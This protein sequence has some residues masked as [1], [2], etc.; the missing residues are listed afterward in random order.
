MDWNSNIG[1]IVPILNSCCGCFWRSTP[2]KIPDPECGRGSRL[3]SSKQGLR[4]S[5]LE[6]SHKIE[7]IPQLQKILP[8]T[9]SFF[10]VS[11]LLFTIICGALTRSKQ[12]SLRSCTR[13]V[14]TSTALNGVRKQYKCV[15]L[16]L[17]GHLY[18]GQQYSLRKWKRKPR[19]YKSGQ[20]CKKQV[21]LGHK[22]T[23]KG[24]RSRFRGGIVM[25]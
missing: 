23:Y 22:D 21:S 11:E 24:T 10:I 25:L 3:A 12:F 5:K 17:F 7:I 16:Q 18:Q 15:F 13:H 2:C 19:N 14:D 6:R 20:H 4:I 9:P 1:S 8:W